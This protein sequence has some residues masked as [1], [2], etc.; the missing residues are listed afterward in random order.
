[1]TNTET[2]VPSE[3]IH[4][5]EQAVLALQKGKPIIVTDDDDRENEGDFI[6]L[7]EKVTKQSMNFLVTEARGLVCVAISEAIAKRLDLPPMVF[8]NEDPHGTAFTVS[9][10]HELTTTGISAAER[11]LTVNKVAD[12]NSS[13]AEFRRPGHIFPL[14]AKDGGVIE[15][16]GHTEA[17]VDLAKLSGVNSAAVICEILKPD[18]EMARRDELLNIAK[19]H[20]LVMISIEELVLYRQ[21]TD[22][23]LVVRAAKV[24]LPAKVM[25][26]EGLET[27][28]FQ[29]LGYQNSIDQAEHVALVAGEL[30]E[31]ST[32]LVRIHSECLTGDVF[33]SCRCDCG[34]QLQYAQSMIA[35][36][37]GIILYMRQEGRGIG[38]INKLKAY[39]LQE[40]G[41]DTVEANHQL[42]FKADERSYELCA[43]MLRDMGIR[44]IKLLTNN[45]DKI[46]A[47]A[48]FG[49]EVIERVPIA[50][51]FEP[52]N[53]QYRH[54]KKSKM[55]HLD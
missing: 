35:K 20:N 10:D 34:P 38:L 54:I 49:I 15:R 47:L 22:E 52:E 23:K 12:P 6:L 43:A 5:I 44:Q 42:G 55:A 30:E 46:N 14:I 53:E 24:K 29:M 33:G 4:K 37:G 28:D 7:A 39:E 31:L 45:P 3:I 51:G 2:K 8:N 36:D 16:R 19:L 40:K 17:A 11:A 18:G 27:V 1:M 32:P 26:N 50:V 13:S 9:I 41:V 48:K 21:L 25:M